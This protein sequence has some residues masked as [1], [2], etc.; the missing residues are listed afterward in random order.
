MS[1]SKIILFTILRVIKIIFGVIL[2]ILGITYAI[3]AI[4]EQNALWLIGTGVCAI[5]AFFLLKKT[6]TEKEIAK[7]RKNKNRADNINFNENFVVESV[8]T[9]SG[10]PKQT[11]IDMRQYYT[12]SMAKK[13]FKALQENY[14]I[15][16][17]TSNL[18]IF[19]QCYNSAI[20][21]ANTLLQ[22]YRAGVKG[23]EKLNYCEL[24]TQVINSS[25][26]LKSVALKNYSQY[27]TTRI[28]AIISNTDKLKRYIENYNKLINLEDEF[29][30]IDEY[31]NL[32]NSTKGKIITLGGSIPEN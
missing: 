14:K 18:D 9:P 11:A 13:D 22:A 12:V 28:N 32:L 27:E 2:C 20:Q 1:K 26:S 4:T 6:K 5:P 25:A 30:F 8:C 15:A 17:S 23:I 21:L 31:E 19:V 24:C 10:T 7:I 3:M 29:L 16:S